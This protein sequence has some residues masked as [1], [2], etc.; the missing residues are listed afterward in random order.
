M[1]GASY[2]DRKE[3]EMVSLVS[4]WLPILVSAVAVF[5]LSSLV[6]M[7]L[8]WHKQDFRPLPDEEAA[9]AALGGAAPGAYTVPHM[10]DRKMLEDPAYRKKLEE[11]PVGFLT[12]LPNG[13]PGM[14]GTMVQWFVWTLVVSA[15][16]AYVVS[17]TIP[18]GV[19]FVLVFQ[20]GSTVAWLAYSWS[21]VQEG[22]W[23]GRPWSHV[24]KQ[25]VDGLIYG[26]ATGAIFGWLYP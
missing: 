23:M 26:L 2:D 21:V 19:G 5:L 1:I 24:V 22:I 10:A 15:T 8:P 14:G 25:L 12:I 16:V 13:R 17:R 4:L 7:A 18:H 9:R 11:G 6:W 3:E 20:V